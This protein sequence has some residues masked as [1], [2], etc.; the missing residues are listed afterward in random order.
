MQAISV[1][2]VLAAGGTDGRPDPTPAF[3]AYG[4][5]V[6]EDPAPERPLGALPRPST[7]PGSH[8][9]YALQWWTFALGSL[10][11]FSILARRELVA[12]AEPAPDDVPVPPRRRRG[13]SAE[14]VEDALIDAQLR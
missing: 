13:P 7:D 6:D 2:Q 3:R 4:A 14:D 9:S 5:L 11:G 10:V 1:A 8:L 12:P